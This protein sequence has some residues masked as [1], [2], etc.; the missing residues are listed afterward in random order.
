MANNNQASSASS[1]QEGTPPADSEKNDFQLAVATFEAEE[2]DHEQVITKQQ[3][4]IASYETT[5]AEQRDLIQQQQATIVSLEGSA[6]NERKLK[7][8]LDEANKTIRSL[9]RAKNTAEDTAKSL[10]ASAEIGGCDM[11]AQDREFLRVVLTTFPE[12]LAKET[13]A[14]AVG[15]KN[16]FET[17][18][19]V[20]TVKPMILRRQ[21]TSAVRQVAKEKAEF[22]VSCISQEINIQGLEKFFVALLNKE[23]KSI[24]FESFSTWCSE[25]KQWNDILNN[26][27]HENKMSMENTERGMQQLVEKRIFVGS[28]FLQMMQ[29][30][31]AGVL[32]NGSMP[33]QL[34]K[35]NDL[36]QKRSPRPPTRSPRDRSMSSPAFDNEKNSY[37]RQSPFPAAR[38]Q[39]SPRR[40]ATCFPA[41]GP[42]C[43]R[44]DLD[45]NHSGRRHPRGMLYEDRR[46]PQS[47]GR[48]EAGSYHNKQ[49]RSSY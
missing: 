2:P 19:L 26:V 13:G 12:I 11:A 24:T 47:G 37:R 46:D 34:P 30:A 36:G 17:A 20:Q 23:Y 6:K 40:H 39:P 45:S 18:R 25:L 35:S 4:V 22:I 31:L 10:R 15:S 21:G 16:L 32:E 5:V 1:R 44:R 42:E 48:R 49:R 28:P 33:V 38:R 9:N 29:N 27:I 3:M 41:E 43:D 14:P 8:K 7:D